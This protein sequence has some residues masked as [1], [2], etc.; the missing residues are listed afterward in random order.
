MILSK[1]EV[2][3]MTIVAIVFAL[4]ALGLMWIL[5]P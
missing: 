5:R 3:G 2:F 4:A 1:K